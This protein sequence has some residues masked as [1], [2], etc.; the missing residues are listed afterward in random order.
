MQT[1][2]Y[3]LRFQTPEFLGNAGSVAKFVAREVRSRAAGTP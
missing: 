3:Q 1:F 2:S